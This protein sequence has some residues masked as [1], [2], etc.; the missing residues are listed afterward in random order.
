[1]KSCRFALLSLLFCFV[2]LLSKAQNPKFEFRAAWIATIENID[3]PSKKGLSTDS[4]KTE[5]I[6]LLDM[7]QHN[8]MNAVVVQIRPVADAFYPSQYEPWSEYL[9]GVQGKAPVPYYDPLQFMIAE[10]HKRGMEFHAWMNPYRAVFNINKS[11]IAATHPTKIFKNWFLVY[12]NEK[13]GYKKYF[14]PGNPEARQ[15]VVDVVKDVVKRYDVDAIHFDDYFYPYRIPGKEFPDAPSYQRF[16][17]GMNKSEWRRSNVDSIILKLATAIKSIKPNVKFGISPFGVWRN[18][19]QDSTGSDTHAGQT[20]Y[21]DLYAD[22]VLWLKK[23]W[24]DYV[25]PQCYW[26]IGFAKADYPELI[27]WWAAN[28]FER[29]VFIGHGL[30]RAGSNAAWRSKN[31]LPHQI[32]MLRQYESIQGSVFFSAK[33][34]YK[35]PNGWADSLRLHYYNTPALIPPMKWID[36]IPPLEP[37]VTFKKNKLIV[38]KQKKCEPLKGFVLYAFNKDSIDIDDSKNI[39]RFYPTENNLLELNNFDTLKKLYA[40]KLFGITSVDINNNESGLVMIK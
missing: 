14:D 31:E 34:F 10:T 26:E 4:Q 27:D 25:V 2:V 13:E 30:Y 28:S 18:K 12:G 7:L 20:N 5:F 36:S 3:W 29:Q 17:H 9:T 15:F 8:G 40:T 35:N 37:V 16:G 33:N 32:S 22:I 38:N 39:V 11:S 24:I 1:M 23:G 21:D 6:H 19:Y